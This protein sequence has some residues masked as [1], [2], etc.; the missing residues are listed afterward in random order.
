[1]HDIEEIAKGEAGFEDGVRA[2]VKALNIPDLEFSVLVEDDLLFIDIPSMRAQLGGPK[3]KCVDLVSRLL[4]ASKM[5]TTMAPSIS[6]DPFDKNVLKLA[7]AIR[8]A[9]EQ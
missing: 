1:M 6:G 5:A 3:S 8:K 2:F 4:D 9:I 7:E